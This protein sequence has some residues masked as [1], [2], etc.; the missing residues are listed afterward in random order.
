MPEP[1]PNPPAVNPT[2]AAY[3]ASVA[4]YLRALEELA[5]AI[6]AREAAAVA[7]ARVTGVEDEIA[8]LAGVIRD[9]Q[10]R[11]EAAGRA[12]TLRVAQRFAVKPG[13]APAPPVGAAGSVLGDPATWGPIPRVPFTE[14]IG[15]VMSRHPVLARTW[16][17]VQ[18]AYN[19]DHAF[20]L[21]R[22]ASTTVTERVQKA[23]AKAIREGKTSAEAVKSIR[24]I[25]QQAQL[26]MRDWTR[27]YAETVFRTNVTTSYAAGRFRQMADPAVRRAIA[28]LRYT[29]VMDVDTRPNHRAADG[30]IAAPE[31]PV[32]DR[33]S[34]PLGYNCRCGVD[35][36]SWPEARAAGIVTGDTTIRPARIPPGAHADPGFRHTGTPY[37]SIYLGV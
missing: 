9:A 32:W 25:A 33:I 29:A 7:G 5:A 4:P 15:D 14:A 21:A 6:R 13:G 22:S 2:T 12:E 17:Q 10:V 16:D 3:A 23:V 30:M 1:R 28:A 36:V 34:P 20:A 11:A 24:G 37:R 35:F 27:A 19:E 8:R 18:A 31:D 26:D